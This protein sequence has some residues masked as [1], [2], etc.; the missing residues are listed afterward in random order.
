MKALKRLCSICEKQI[1]VKY[2]KKTY[3]R[4]GYY[5]RIHSSEGKR[6]YNRW[7]CNSCF[8]KLLGSFKL[9][10][11]IKKERE[12]Y[13]IECKKKI[14]IDNIKQQIELLNKKII[15]IQN[16]ELSFVDTEQIKVE[17]NHNGGYTCPNCKE[18]F[19]L[20]YTLREHLWKKHRMKIK[21]L[22]S[23]KPEASASSQTFAE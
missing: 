16:V 6:F 4:I 13:Q 10:D 18:A 23:G 2:H 17:S 12:Q 9:D 7:F 5:P 3:R 19:R 22:D 11:L 14:K 8:D 15:D 1:S 20:R 21:K